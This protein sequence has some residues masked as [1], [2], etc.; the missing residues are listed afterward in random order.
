MEEGE[1]SLKLVSDWAT[2]REM[3]LLLRQM[4]QLLWSGGR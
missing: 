1:S 3:R 4:E 2:E